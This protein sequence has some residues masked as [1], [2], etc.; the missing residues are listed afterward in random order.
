MGFQRW[1]A[2]AVVFWAG[3]LFA[4]SV[5]HRAA[6]SPRIITAPLGEKRFLF[7]TTDNHAVLYHEEGTSSVLVGAVDNLYYHD[8]QTSISYTEPF[9]SD[10]HS[11]C[12]NPEDAKNYLTLLEKAGDKVLICGSNAC[13]PTCWNWQVNQEK[14]SRTD[15]RGLAPFVLSQNGI[16]LVDGNNVYSSVKPHLL[17]GNVPRFRRIHG[18]S[19]LYT[20]DLVMQHPEFIKGTIIKQ[21][22]A[23]NNKIY[24]FFNENNPEWQKNAAASRRIARV[25]QLC[26]GDRGGSG[27]LSGAKWST[28]LKSTLLCDNAVTGRHFN[29]LQD[30][31]IMKSDDW[32]QTKIYGLFLNEWDY[33]AVC[34]YSLGEIAK[35]LQTSPLKGYNEKF[36][37]VRPGQCLEASTPSET[38]RV[39]DRH[40]EVTHNVKYQ[41]MFFYS[42]YHYQKLTVHQVP[43][44]DGVTYD[45]FYL[46]T[47]KGTIHKVVAWAGGAFNIMEIQ[48]FQQPG[49]IKSMILDNTTKELFVSSPAEVVRLPLAM[50]SVYKDN[51]GSCVLA[52]DPYCGWS[53]GKCT[54]SAQDQLE[55]G[56]TLQ[57]LT[58]DVSPD[59]CA[60]ESSTKED[61][62]EQPEAVAV[63]SL[64]RYYLNCTIESHHANYTWFHNDKSI[65]HCG[66]GRPQCI[67]FIN[68][69]TGELYGN[70]TCV[71][72]EDWFNRTILTQHLTKPT[73][74]MALKSIT[75]L[76]YSWATKPSLSI[77]LGLCLGAVIL[78]IP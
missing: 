77:W 56:A 21:E 30:V 69:M 76:P 45:V 60:S 42:K 5:A 78:L 53:N 44:A 50:C 33:S 1:G 47:D 71:S 8:F 13:S 67:Y 14:S 39:I 37:P 59:V 22:E 52:R 40:P 68:K 23:L 58:H 32:Q 73:E 25:G 29:R 10:V 43:A 55:N 74:T 27:S 19:Q 63:P 57:A 75:E 35:I 11:Q 20:S 15:G 46:A 62:N 66:G 48:P 49:V 41:S 28:F 34:V 3:Q 64:S 65:A 72:Q 31:F 4:L 17:N 7:N 70:Y 6:M 51:C 54:N 18:F 26:Q 38:F 61:G 2:F 36:P 24:L 12:G 9:H 16:V